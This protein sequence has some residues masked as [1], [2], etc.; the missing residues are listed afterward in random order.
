MSGRHQPH[1]GHTTPSVGTWLHRL[2][3]EP[4]VAA[5][6]AFVMVLALTPR[7]AA[8]VALPVLGLLVLAAAVAARLRPG[9]VVRRLAVIVPFLG[10]ALLLPLVS[11]GPRTA[12]GPLSLSSEGLRAG[13]VIGAKTT[14]GALTS[15]VLS[16][17]TAST[18]IV[19]ALGRLGV[20][21]VLVAIAGFMLRYLDLIAGELGRRRVAMASRG[22][23][24]RSLA[25]AK[26]LAGAL[27]TT[28]VRSYERGERVHHAM[29]TRGFTG[30]MPALAP[31]RAR[32]A[33]WLAAALFPLV[34][35]AAVAAAWL[36][37]R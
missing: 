8:P 6:V 37:A 30:T 34:G 35:A 14:I 16:G 25:Q 32:T 20:P 33:D 2:A 7:S 1:S 36:A 4:K 10:L 5:A 18:D 15:I 9:F 31:T 23:R 21:R 3:P 11:G 26:P 17:T 12:V 28:F 19:A 22:F 13:A 24:P 29:V 27:G